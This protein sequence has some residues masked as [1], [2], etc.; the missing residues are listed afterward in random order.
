VVLALDCLLAA[1][2]ALLSLVQIDLVN[3]MARGITPGPSEFQTW[4]SMLVLTDSA[5]LG[6]IL[7]GAIV[8]GMWIY[9]AHKNVEELGV[10]GKS[11]S[12]GWA[13]GWFF[14][15]IGNLF[16]PCQAMLELWK[17]SDPRVLIGDRNWRRSSGT[18]LIAGWWVGWLL[19]SILH[20]VATG[21]SRDQN[22]S[23]SDYKTMLWLEIAAMGVTILSAACLI[24]LIHGIRK[25][26][27][28]QFQSAGNFPEYPEYAE[29]AEYDNR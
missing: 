19:S 5:R 2:T 27:I 24:A 16:K 18:A 17:A 21:F 12:P 11:I 6:L 10:R 14:V 3:R 29:S 7:I 22:A 28:A 1:G 4:H 25:R 26:Q 20:N 13:V 23:M 9:R 8:I 15:P